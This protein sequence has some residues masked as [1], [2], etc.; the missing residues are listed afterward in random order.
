MGPMGGV[1]TMK[2]IAS[3]RQLEAY[4]A[5]LKYNKNTHLIFQELPQYVRL[6]NIKRYKVTFW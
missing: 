5:F 2:N 3:L 1:G 4:E 6:V